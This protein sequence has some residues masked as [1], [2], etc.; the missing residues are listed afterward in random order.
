MHFTLIINQL[1]INLIAI[2]DTQLG[3]ALALGDQPKTTVDV[4]YGDTTVFLLDEEVCRIVR[5]LV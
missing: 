1:Q 3:F 2:D 5:E 4:I